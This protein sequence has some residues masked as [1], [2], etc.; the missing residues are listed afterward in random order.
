M[1]GA[2]T[3]SSGYNEV[4]VCVAL[5]RR[6]L[7]RNAKLL[8][9]PPMPQSPL[10]R[11]VTTCTVTVPASLRTLATNLQ[12]APAV[13]RAADFA[14]GTPQWPQTPATTSTATAPTF[15]AGSLTTSARRPAANAEANPLRFFDQTTTARK[16][17]IPNCKR[18]L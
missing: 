4:W 5:A 12:S 15:A 6:W 18:R 2:R 7:W 17:Q 1:G 3:D 8:P 10:R 16:L 11:L 14:Q 13:P 9:G